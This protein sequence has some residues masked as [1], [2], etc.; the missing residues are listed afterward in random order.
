MKNTIIV[1]V[2]V[3][4]FTLVYEILF[5]SIENKLEH[6]KTT[7]LDNAL[8][9]A[10]LTLLKNELDPHFM[11]NALNSLSWLIQKDTDKADNFITKLSE[12]Y[13]YFLV[14]KNKEHVTLTEELDF[15]YK[16]FRAFTTQV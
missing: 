10:Q 14:N 3:V 2:A 9:K 15:I 8:T 16:Y 12:V 1:C 11:Y 4:V 7:Q 5:L 6:I 13:R